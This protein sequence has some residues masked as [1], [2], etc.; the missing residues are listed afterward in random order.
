MVTS[1]TEVLLSLETVTTVGIRSGEFASM[2][3]MNVRIVDSAGNVLVA[4]PCLSPRYV[5]G[6]VITA[7][8]RR[9]GSNPALP[10]LNRQCGQ[11]NETSWPVDVATGNFWHTFGGLSIPGRGTPLNF[12]FTYNSSAANDDGPLG[13]G[14]THSYNMRLG[15]TPNPTS[16]TTV[17]VSQE[18]GSQVNFFGSGTTWAPPPRANATLTK[19]GDGSWSYVRRGTQAYTFDSTGRLV[20][21]R[22]LTDPVP[23][24]PI[25]LASDR[26]IDRCISAGLPAIGIAAAGHSRR[27][28]GHQS[29]EAHGHQRAGRVQ[30]RSPRSSRGPRSCRRL[31]AVEDF[32]RLTSVAAGSRG[33]LDEPQLLTASSG[34]CVANRGRYGLGADIIASL[35][36]K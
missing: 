10:C 7:G 1:A 24:Y 27:S 23:G 36:R 34:G 3:I 19:N 6:G 35:D 29:A 8:E 21:M 31:A 26:A 11:T 12:G 18:N 9:G 5:N 16:P 22:N 14:W 4:N 13:F 32:E 15:F 25:P 28:P 30:W 20:S 33:G 17:T 2:H